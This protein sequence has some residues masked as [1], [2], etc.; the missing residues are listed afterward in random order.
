MKPVRKPRAVEPA[1]VV[2]VANE[3]ASIQSEQARLVRRQ[4]TLETELRSIAL[5]SG[6]LEHRRLELL[7]EFD[8]VA[9]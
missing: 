4:D 8:K 3:I 7:R 1:K 2:T 9:V 6:N 5:R